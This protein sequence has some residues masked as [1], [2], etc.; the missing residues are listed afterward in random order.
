MSSTAG[1]RIPVSSTAD[2]G[3]CRT[4]GPR[5]AGTSTFTDGREDLQGDPPRSRDGVE[6]ASFALVGGDVV[7]EGDMYS[8]QSSG[9]RALGSR[10]SPRAAPRHSICLGGDPVGEYIS[11]V[12]EMR[13]ANTN[14]LTDGRNRL[15]LNANLRPRPSPYNR[16][17]AQ[18]DVQQDERRQAGGATKGSE[19]RHGDDT[20]TNGRERTK[21]LLEETKVHVALA[22]YVTANQSKGCF[23]WRGQRRTDSYAAYSTPSLDPGG[24]PWRTSRPSVKVLAPALRGPQVRHRPESAVEETGIRRP[25]VEDMRAVTTSTADAVPPKAGTPRPVTRTVVYDHSV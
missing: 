10:W 8:V 12:E 15:F 3:L 7:G 2:S 25:A 1:R 18:N 5:R 6:K 21:G 23:P 22:D 24:S 17:G 20:T 14:Y 13:L 16:A 19:A 11:F 9:P 4:C